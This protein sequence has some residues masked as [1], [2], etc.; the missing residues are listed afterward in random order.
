MTIF[1]NTRVV[2]ECGII[3]ALAGVLSK[4]ELFR[5]PN[6]GSI[7][8]EML[9]L[10]VLAI[11]HGVMIGLIAGAIFGG[12]LKLMISGGMVV[13][14]LQYLLDYPLAFSVL[15]L[16]GLARLHKKRTFYLVGSVVLAVSSRFV[17]HWI[18][19]TIYFANFA[20]PGQPGWLYSLIYNL[21]HMIP[22]TILII[23]LIYPVINRLP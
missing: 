10:I 14:P 16:A 19:G 11:R 6:E 9:P 4:F 17:I 13:H 5:L 12:V 1:S 20:P 23:I 2:S 21:S 15:G 8:L 18:S 22:S 7:S 3:M